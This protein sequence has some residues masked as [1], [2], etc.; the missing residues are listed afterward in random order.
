MIGLIEE[1]YNAQKTEN[2]KSFTSFSYPSIEL[3]VIGILCV[4]VEVGVRILFYTNNMYCTFVLIYPHITVILGELLK[5]VDFH[6]VYKM[7][8]DTHPLLY[9]PKL[10][11]LAILLHP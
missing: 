3:G 5:S 9:V 10:P 4:I 7:H 2:K 8:C 1:L 6:N 11:E